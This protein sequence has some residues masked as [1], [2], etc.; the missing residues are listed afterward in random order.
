VIEGLGVVDRLNPAVHHSQDNEESRSIIS[1][2]FIPRI[3]VVFV[4]S[5]SDKASSIALSTRLLFAHLEPPSL[6]LKAMHETLPISPIFR[7]R[8]PSGMG[9]LA[10]PS[11]M[12]RCRLAGYI[13]F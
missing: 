7:V 8:L 10:R 2:H 1:F 6:Y 9:L 5:G 4:T 3:L 13:H 12:G 11:A